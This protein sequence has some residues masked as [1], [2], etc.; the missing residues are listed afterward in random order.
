M[1]NKMILNRK[2]YKE[3]KKMDHQQMSNYLESFYNEAYSK[4]KKDAEGLT[5]KE[6]REAILKVKGIGCAKTEAIMKAVVERAKEK[7]N[8]K[9]HKV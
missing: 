5:E 9:S 4:G 2:T 1:V 3:I 8:E 6:M 7:E